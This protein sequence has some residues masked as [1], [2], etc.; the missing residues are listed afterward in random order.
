[1]WHDGTFNL[2]YA[3]Q[4]EQQFYEIIKYNVIQ[5]FII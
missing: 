2:A 1:M 5:Q 3:K 4:A